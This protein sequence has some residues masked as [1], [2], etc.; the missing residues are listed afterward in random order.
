MVSVCLCVC[1]VCT[2][3]LCICMCLRLSFSFSFSSLRD[4]CAEIS[5]FRRYLVEAI[6]LSEM[7]I[8]CCVAHTRT[9]LL[10]VA[11]ATIPRITMCHV[12]PIVMAIGFVSVCVCVRG[13]VVS[14]N[15]VWRFE[16]QHHFL[17]IFH[18]PPHLSLPQYAIIRQ[19][20]D[21]S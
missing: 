9:L 14:G 20:I 6:K 10:S 18:A 12:S 5:A 17:K 1:A 21:Q 7:G 3:Q 11:M 15:C 19:N 2:M 4:A 16:Q 13:V 8:M